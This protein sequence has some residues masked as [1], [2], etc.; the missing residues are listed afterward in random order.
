MNGEPERTPPPRR[1]WGW[2]EWSAVAAAF[3]VGVLLGP[4]VLRASQPLPF[5]SA[6]GRVVAVGELRNTLNHQPSGAVAQ[7]SR[8]TA[9]GISFRTAEGTYCR[10][11]AM[12]PGPAGLA[13]REWGE[14]VVETLARN[15]RARHD[16]DSYR[17]TGTAFPELI[18]LAVEARMQGEPLTHDEERELE[19]RNWRAD[20]RL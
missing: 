11:F 12:S 8:R 7:D 17:Q 20:E 6:G 2:Q 14:W 16:A 4:Y 18:R 9:I 10:T 15:P 5:M 13:C 19:A 3:V 1:S